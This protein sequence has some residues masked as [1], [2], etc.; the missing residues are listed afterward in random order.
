MAHA[1]LAVLSR[2]AFC[3]SGDVLCCQNL[4]MTAS[5]PEV[6]HPKRRAA[7]RSTDGNFCYLFGRRF[8]IDG[9]VREEE[10]VSLT[11][12]ECIQSRNS[13]DILSQFDYRQS[14]TDRVGIMLSASHHEPC[15][16]V[17]LVA[18]DTR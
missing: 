14:R 1:F 11:G 6:Q 9:A 15:P 10:Q 16:V 18:R 4:K 2:D 5:Q 7:Y 17:F 13:M 12:D 3:R 8:H